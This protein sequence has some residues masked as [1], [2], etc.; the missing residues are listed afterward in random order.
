VHALEI[1]L[2]GE[3]SENAEIWIGE[4]PGRLNHRTL[5]KK[6][7]VKLEYSSDWYSD[8]C[9]FMLTE[10]EGRKGHLTLKYRFQAGSS[11]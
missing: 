5:L 4:E 7:E 10:K 9:F 1:E 8:R 2:T 6:G 3:L 11:N